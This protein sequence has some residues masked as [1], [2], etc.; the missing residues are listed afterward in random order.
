MSNVLGL[1]VSTK[2]GWVVLP[3]V[4]SPIYGEQIFPKLKG[5]D[6]ICHF[7]QWA[8]DLVLKFKPELTFI[9]GYG[10]ANAHTLATLV[11]IGTAVR[12]GLMRAK[13]EWVDIP[14]TILKKFATGVGNAK[15]DKIALEVYKQWGVE[16]ATDNMVDAYVL[17]QMAR[18]YH[19]KLEGKL[20]SVQKKILTT[21]REKGK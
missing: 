8:N 15:K 12:L 19:W 18:C 10:Y 21:L 13:A 16:P 1:D 14:P 2:T 3:H 6:R 11:E 17:A 4:G 5:F 7:E 20:F 9:E